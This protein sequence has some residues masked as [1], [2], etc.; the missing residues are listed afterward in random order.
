MKKASYLAV[1]LAA[2]LPT[3]AAVAEEVKISVPAENENVIVPAVVARKPLLFVGIAL[4]DRIHEDLDFGLSVIFVQDKSPAA[5]AGIEVGDV[6]LS[7]DGQK[8]FN[9]HQFFKLLRMYEPGATIPIELLRDGKKIETT[10]HLEI[11]PGKVIQ[12]SAL[13]AGTPN[14]RVASSPARDDVRIIIN[15][16]EY[17]LSDS[18]REWRDRV[19][20]TKDALIIRTK[21][22]R[23]E[24][25]AFAER[26]RERMPEPEQARVR[27]FKIQ[28]A[29]NDLSN[30]ETHTAFSRHYF[31]NGYDIVYCGRDCERRLIV[32]KLDEDA[33]IF[34]GPCATQEEIDAIPQEVKEIV[35]KFMPLK[36]K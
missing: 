20:V 2:L 1:G 25:S 35:E 32:K 17:S 34:D 31:G 22:F 6:L 8:L 10:V 23:D 15:G 16:K 19:A 30:A 14:N 29:E 12:K 27:T 26:L 24:V 11:R 9:C 4:Q 28:M 36:A 21:D 13:A 3:V 5:N 33:V 18:I 7:F